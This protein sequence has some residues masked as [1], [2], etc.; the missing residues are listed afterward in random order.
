VP[1]T[2]FAPRQHIAVAQLAERVPDLPPDVDPVVERHR[3]PPCG[4][5]H[6]VALTFRVGMLGG[7]TTGTL[8]PRLCVFRTIGAVSTGPSV[9]A[10]RVKVLA[11]R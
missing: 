8:D 6:P 9:T 4:R 5:G 1:T 3:W 11:V 10:P 2:Q 7:R